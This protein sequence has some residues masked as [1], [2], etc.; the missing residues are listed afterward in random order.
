MFADGHRIRCSI[1]ARET[2]ARTARGVRSGRAA[3]RNSECSEGRETVCP[4]VRSIAC[5]DGSTVLFKGSVVC[6]LCVC[7]THRFEQPL[8]QWN[9][10]G[11]LAAENGD[12]GGALSLSATTQVHTSRRTASTPHSK[13]QHRNVNKDNECQPAKFLGCAPNA[14]SLIDLH[15][16]SVHDHVHCADEPVEIRLHRKRDTQSRHFVQRSI[17][18]ALEWC[19]PV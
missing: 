9:C 19:A 10:N 3:R 15:V 11:T 16:L 6:P 13:R 12:M 7:L 2:R 8:F 18:Q 1:H 17:V 5:N 4:R 14:P